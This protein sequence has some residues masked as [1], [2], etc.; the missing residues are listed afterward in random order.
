M[1]SCLWFLSRWLISLV[2]IW[3]FA[4]TPATSSLHVDCDLFHS[5]YLLFGSIMI[6]VLLR[7]FH[8]PKFLFH[9]SIESTYLYIYIYIESC[10]VVVSHHR[11]FLVYNK[12]CSSQ[13][14]QST[15]LTN[16]QANREEKHRIY[17]EKNSENCDRNHLLRFYCQYLPTS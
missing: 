15:C 7:I 3:P 5:F 8:H 1:V 16:S 17:M 13:W 11:L 6:V 12:F 10:F 4:A 2:V 9:I 14:I